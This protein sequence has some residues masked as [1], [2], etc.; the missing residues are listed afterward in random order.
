MLF[1]GDSCI[2][3]EAGSG[4][5]SFKRHKQDSGAI[6]YSSNI[7]C[8]SLFIEPVSWM[9]PLL[10]GTTEGKVLITVYIFRFLQ[11]RNLRGLFC[12]NFNGNIPS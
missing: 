1:G 2:E 3:H 5:V 4:Q 10:E 8:T 11:F 9:L 7:K 6:E 12:G